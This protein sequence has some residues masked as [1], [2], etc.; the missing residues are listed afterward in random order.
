MTA[1]PTPTLDS[2]D[3][4]TPHTP[5][6]ASGAQRLEPG[7]PA[8]AWDVVVFGREVGRVLSDGRIVG[9]AE[10]FAKVF[11]SSRDVKR[12]VGATAWV[13][14]EDIALDATIDAQGRLVADTSV[15]Q[16]ADNLGLNKST[17]TRDLA[18]L[19]DYGFVLH[20]EA[21]DEASGRWDASRSVLDPS[22]CVERLTHTPVAEQPPGQSSPELDD[23]FDGAEATVSACTGH[24]GTG[25]GETGRL[26]R[27]R[28]A[29]DEEQHA[30]HPGDHDAQEALIRR[31]RS[32]GVAVSVAEDLVA[33]FPAPQI[34]DA[35][36]VLPARRCSNAAGWLVRA[37]SD[38][39]Q[40]HDE[41]Q[42]L[43]T[44]RTHVQQHHNDALATQ[45]RQ[46]QREAW[47]TG[48]GAAVS[49]ALTDTQ[50]AAAVHRVT[51]PV[52]ALDRRSAPV[53]AS[54][55]LAWA[56]TTA[57]SAPYEPLD[58]ALNNALHEHTS[59]PEIAL[60]ELPD[61]IPPAPATTATADPDAFR[62]RVRH[63]INDLE[64]SHPSL[65]PRLEGGSDAP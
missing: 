3:A 39:W 50:L 18:R 7:G 57:T 1:D 48:W 53:A 26:V 43:R 12:A 30:Q 14:L 52:A 33:R 20:E 9:R 34:A 64:A 11:A 60:V 46:E 23:E 21:R 19:R 25:H 28:H 16:I 51:R 40:L 4:A 42:R 13:I 55:L 65:K 15:R 45:V 24:G 22:A 54:Q 8:R 29:V 58:T 56:I 37:I 31:L 17:V 38:G 63:A 32:A 27:H 61:D 10:P 35:L 36:D 2:G 5:S 6:S 41:A 59:D 62:R 44:A 47:L 49:D